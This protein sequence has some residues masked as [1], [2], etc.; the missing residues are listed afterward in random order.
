MVDLDVLKAHGVSSDRMREICE[1]DTKKGAKPKDADVITYTRI[2]N[3]IRD[4]VQSGM[5]YNLSNY[6]YY[7]AADLA[8]DVPFRQTT[9][10]LLQGF[11]D[12]KTPDKE[13]LSALE[14]VDMSGMLT[15]FNKEG[16]AISGRIDPKD[17]AEVK[18]NAPTFFGIFIPLAKQ[19]TTIRVAAIVN[20]YRQ[21]PLFKFE[22]AKST[23][24]NRTKSDIIT[25]RVE[26]MSTQYG[27]F[28]VIKQAVLHMLHYGTAI[29]FPAEEWHTEPQRLRVPKEDKDGKIIDGKYE[30]KEVVIKEG[31]RF[32][33]P[34][35]SRTF[36][37]AAYRPSTINSDSGVRFGAYWRIARVGEVMNNPMYWG[38]KDKI[39]DNGI[40]LKANNPGFFNTVYNSC[41][42]KFGPVG[43]VDRGDRE[44]KLSYYTANE[45]DRAITFTEYFEKIN[46]KTEGIG[47]YDYEVWFRYVVAGNDTVVY[48]CPLAHC[49]MVY[50]GYDALE[51][52]AQNASMTLEILPFQDH[53]SN[54]FSQYILTVKQN[55]TNLTFFDT[56]QVDKKVIDEIRNLGQKNYT[57]TN[58]AP[59]DMRTNRMGQNDP[60]KA[61]QTFQFQHQPTEELTRGV[62]ELLKILE[63][64]L[65]ISP[66]ELAQT[67]T[68]ELT[69]E[70]VKNMNAAKSTRY[71]FTAGAVDRGVYALKSLIYA[72]LMNYADEDL[73]ARL[74]MPIDTTALDKL[75]FKVEHTDS[76]GKTALVTGK[77]SAILIDSFAANRDGD[78]RVANAQTAQAMT[79]VL[80]AVLSNERLFAEV[81]EK[82]VLNLINEISQIAGLPKDFQFQPTGDGARQQAAAMQESQAQL[83]KAAEAIEQKT[84]Q[85]I[86]QQLAP[87]FQNQADKFQK[88]EQELQQLAAMISPPPPAPPQ[89]PMAPPQPLPPYA[90]PNSP[91]PVNLGPEN[92]SA[93]MAPPPGGP[94]F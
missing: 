57:T 12:R 79:Q 36:I 82:Q 76:D 8:W 63:R 28:D 18:V 67:A 22:A 59:M 16:K 34:H 38:N 61:F 33:L 6:K 25:D 75:G 47:D 87:V 60:S 4:R 41:A 49:P 32:N 71:E 43:T 27:Y 44:V 51:S 78:L 17:V 84:T 85:D 90:A 62:S 2:K 86:A 74:P 68:H 66:Q 52:R 81:G 69:A 50:F 64:V 13:I 80:Q 15:V 54:L 45:P 88:M 70:E 14:N 42:L 92:P 1:S 89:V 72:S 56:N 24:L 40:D 9:Y 19:Y 3:R 46:P 58:F 35:P 20:S 39:P 26:M 30:E 5:N 73:W 83:Q 29:L 48:A 10:S 91:I 21:I 53:V 77:K 93:G 7:H 55:L 11:L 31:L 65:V 94:P 23:V 37:D